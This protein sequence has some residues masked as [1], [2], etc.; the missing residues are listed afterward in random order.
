[1][2][3]SREANDFFTQLHLM[4]DTYGNGEQPRAIHW[5]PDGSGFIVR[6]WGWVASY[7]IPLFFPG[8]KQQDSFRRRMNRNGIRKT[9]RGLNKGV[10]QHENG[11]FFRGSHH[12]SDTTIDSE[13]T[14]FFG[15]LE[16]SITNEMLTRHHSEI[17]LVSDFG[18]IILVADKVTNRGRDYDS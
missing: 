2:N 12:I 14:E 7:A 16:N 15:H 4:I 17:S 11:A 9:Q 3:E 8:I 6:D 13:L 18:R 1:M 5:S 10:W